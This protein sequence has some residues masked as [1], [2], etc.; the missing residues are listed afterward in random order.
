MELM[1]D[2][3]GREDVTEVS[4]SGDVIEGKGQPI[5][6]TEPAGGKKPNKA[7]GFLRTG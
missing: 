7:N 1:Y 5:L 2:I 3:P 4:I 6:G